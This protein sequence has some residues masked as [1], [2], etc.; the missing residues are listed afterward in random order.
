M[1]NGLGKETAGKGKRDRKRGRGR[2]GDRIIMVHETAGRV[3]DPDSRR[4]DFGQSGW[5]ADKL[6]PNRSGR[7][8]QQTERSDVAVF[9]GTDAGRA[10][11]SHATA[12]A[13]Y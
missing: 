4:T 6:R 10:G 13:I 7:A 5:T 2:S 1:C 3:R 12:A 11:C 8:G 9:S